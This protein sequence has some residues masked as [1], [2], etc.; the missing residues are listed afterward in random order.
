M[1][2]E[3]ATQRNAETFRRNLGTLNQA[4]IGVILCRTR[5]PWRAI[6]TIRASAFA[7]RMNFRLW[8]ISRGWATYDRQNPQ[9]DPTTDGMIDP[10]GALGAVNGTGSNEGMG[11]GY[12][13]MMNPHKPITQSI[14]MVQLLK[15]YARLFNECRKR[16]VLITP[17]GWDLPPELEDDITILDFDP[18]AYAELRDSYERIFEVLGN[19]RPAFTP[20]EVDGLLAG[21]AG[22]TAHEFENALSRAII[23]KKAAL[24]RVSAADIGKIVI[25]V[26]TEVVKRS[27]VLEVMQADSI[28]N[29]GGL[30]NLKAW[31]HKRA[32]C[33]G[34]DARDFGV[35]PPKGIALIGPPGTGK[36]ASAKAIASVL[37]IPLIRFDVGRIFN[38]LVGQSEARVRAALKMVDAMAPCVL[39]IDEADKAFAGQAGGGGGDSGVGMRV[40]GAI[41]T[42]MQE[43]KAPV[44]MVVTANRTQNL[45][46]EFLRRGRL[47]EI[48]SVTVPHEV[49]RLEVLKIHLRKRGKNPDDVPGLEKAVERSNGYVSAEL[50]AAVKDSI[51]EAFSSNRPLDGELIAE[52]FG[53]MVP[54]SVAFAADFAAMQQWAEQNARP[55]SLLPS[56]EVAAPARVRQR[57]RPS[58]PMPGTTGRVMNLDG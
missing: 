22:M 46:S 10:V 28:S 39:M 48:F 40:L 5:E 54:L 7:D 17:P 51:I 26:K 12:F 18:P 4:A 50:E 34:Q 3:Q 45:P 55:A 24:P 38:S 49:E 8:T 43:T 53:N 47:D 31:V 29:I 21:G 11:E 13:V 57:Q 25:G 52:Q 44:F 2:A 58:S 41:L 35:E 9:A 27:E 14:V 20:E 16:L 19:R 56:G 42:W 15:E 30:E 36:T 32:L 6:E 23:T 33:F 37:R 1:S